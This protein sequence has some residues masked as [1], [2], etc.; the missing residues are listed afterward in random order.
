M[1]NDI[2]PPLKPI[3]REISPEAELPPPVLPTELTSSHPDS[4]FGKK[5]PGKRQ[6]WLVI[7]GV[8]V[9]LILVGILV[10]VG[11]YL[12]A[13][14]PLDSDDAEQQR[15]IVLSGEGP[16]E[17]GQNL[18]SEGLIR[19]STAFDIYTRISG[20]YNKL[21]A[22]AYAFSPNQTPSVIAAQIE[23]GK[24]TDFDVT[25]LPGLTL[26]QLADDSIEG[27]LAN[28]GFDR[29]EIESA[30]N[31]SYDHPL[32]AD[33][34]QEHDLEGYLFPETYRIDSDGSLENLFKRSFDELY[35]RLEADGLLE[36]FKEQDLN[37]HEA[38]TLASIVQK[39]VSDEAEQRQVAQVF[40]KRYE[41]GIMLGADPTF[42]YAAEK[43]GVEP[44]VMLDSPYN[45]RVNKGLPPGPIANM[46]YSAIE[47]VARPAGGDFLFFVA[48]EDGNTYFARTD[49]EHQQNIDR[50]CGSLCDEFRN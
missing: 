48:G 11:W 13:L 27:S 42:I 10:V 17:I 24:V 41:E 8:I 1:N 18:E 4:E 30:A 14:S 22:G 47:A 50:Y 40:L 49:E 20:V 34:P 6:R 25:I 3:R 9:S 26:K 5:P 37:I 28:Q 12:W 39:E 44:R 2:R 7:S 23:S 43:M 46:N 29:D 45:T 32:L 15:F 35:R 16:A 33:K 31:A 19:S 36:R 21:Q 38:L